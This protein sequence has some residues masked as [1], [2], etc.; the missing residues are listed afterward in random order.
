M[1]STT[2]ALTLCLALDTI[3]ARAGE[4]FRDC[5]DCPPMVVVPAGTYQMG[6]SE[7]NIEW[8]LGLYA[9]RE[10]LQQE[11]PQHRVDVASFGISATEITRGQFNAFVLATGYQAQ[12]PCTVYSTSKRTVVQS[13][14]SNWRD[15]G[16][17]QAE[18][19]PVVC[20]NWNDAKAYVNW[21]SQKTGKSYRLPTEAEWEYAARAGSPSERPWG[22]A[23]SD[24][25]R[26]ANVADTTAVRAFEW[27]PET[28]FRCTDGFAYTAP[29]ARFR[30]N[31]FGLSDMIG[32]VGEW[33]EDCYNTSYS[34]APTNGS[35]W[36][37]GD[38]S[39]R[40]HRGGS[41]LNVPW[42]LRSATRYPNASNFRSDLVG[43]RVA[44]TN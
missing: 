8:T 38:C 5:S 35:A 37:S 27:D 11:T 20:V 19:H 26:N 1:R 30:A 18:D 44:R 4:Q 23:I 2:L 42:K 9:K 24:V 6:S 16:F 43:F 15:P 40:V 34:G 41:W 33:V 14:E 10:E 29:A 31:G 21:L 22:R 36:L 28:R 13:E 12:G 7:E 32:N 17:G 25:C 39:Q 3:S